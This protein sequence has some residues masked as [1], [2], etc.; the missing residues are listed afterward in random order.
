[1]VRKVNWIY[2]NDIN[3]SYVGLNTQIFLTS[4]ISRDNPRKRGFKLMT[5]ASNSNE[6]NSNLVVFVQQYAA[7]LGHWQKSG[8]K[9]YLSGNEDGTFSEDSLIKTAKFYSR[10]MT[11]PSFRQ[12]VIV[13]IGL[14]GVEVM[15]ELNN[16]CGYDSSEVANLDE[17]T[18]FQSST[19]ELVIE[20]YGTLGQ[21]LGRG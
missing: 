9:L 7:K 14:G 10:F 21:M 3:M 12:K 19:G 1:M 15:Q 4:S 8:S 17:L 6:T 2:A 11:L 13:P 20:K 18:G 5:I 16:R